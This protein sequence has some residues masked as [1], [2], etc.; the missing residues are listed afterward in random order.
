MVGCVLE[1]GWSVE[2]TADRFQVDA[3]T[4]RKWVAR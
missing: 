2:S 3:K 4:V 1:M